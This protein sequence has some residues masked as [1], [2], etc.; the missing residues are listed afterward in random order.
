MDRGVVVRVF[1][2]ADFEVAILAAFGLAIDKADQRADRVRALE[3][4]DI[5]GMAAFSSRGPTD[6]LRQKPDI[7]APG[8]WILSTRSLSSTSDGALA[9]DANHVYM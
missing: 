2:V 6:A 5:D 7:S 9:Y 1:E 3:G 8:T 4:G